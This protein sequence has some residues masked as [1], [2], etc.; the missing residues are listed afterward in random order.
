M[1]MGC[2][3]PAALIDLKEGETMLDLGSGGGID[4]LLS[5]RRVGPTGFVFGVGMTDEML[6]LAQANKEKAGA[7][8]VAFLKG[9]IESMP[10]EHAMPHRGAPTPARCWQGG[11]TTGLPATRYHSG[12]VSERLC[13]RQ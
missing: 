12:S 11:Y 3:N 8:N 13:S 2:G 4:V 1:R 6:A 10:M 5:A 7:T 9:Q